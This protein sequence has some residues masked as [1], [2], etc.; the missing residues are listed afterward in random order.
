MLIA[1]A[2]GKL[3][4]KM[5]FPAILGWLFTGV[6]VGPNL[7]NLLSNDV[8]GSNWYGFVMIVA[9]MC[10]GALV[11]VNFIW[12]EFKKTGA[13]I[14]TLNLFQMAGSF[15]VVFAIGA[16]ICNILNIPILIAVLFASISIAFAPAPALAIVEQYKPEGQLTDT[17]VPITVTDSILATIIFYIII[18][19][20]RSGVAT[21]EMNVF[22]T[23]TFI[24]LIPTV[25]GLGLG[26]LSSKFISKKN[27]SGKNKIISIILFGLVTIVGYLVD[28][29]LYPEPMLSYILLG[30]G[31]VVGIVNLVSEELAEEFS[32]NW[33]PITGIG[34]MIIIVNSSSPINIKL[35]S[36]IGWV[37]AIYIVTRAIGRIGGNYIGSKIIK[38]PEV[39]TK[40][41]GIATL[42]HS[43]VSL[44]HTTI[45][46]GIAPMIS[47]QGAEVLAMSLPVAALIN[48][49]IA[50]MLSKKAYE[51]SGEL[52]KS[53]KTGKQVEGSSVE[54]S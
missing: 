53:E 12:K 40:Y 49:V 19:V 18:C 46:M 1:Y 16:V 29:F 51:W 28:T 54:S 5:K 31:F 38:A 23:L 8:I 14:L 17:V 10:L 34:L 41:C 13:N 44:V 43:G 20:I 42:P 35:L 4:Q 22:M 32:M 37:S 36:S 48:E 15:I 45:A 6:I 39:V 21:V 27:S 50:I 24:M 2:A 25:I 3:I 11:G 30:L 7:L 33:G 9:Q 47:I 52:K 26:A